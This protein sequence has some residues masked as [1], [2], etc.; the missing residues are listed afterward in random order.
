MMVNYYFD[1]FNN[2]IFASTFSDGTKYST[3]LIDT[4]FI[5]QYYLQLSNNCS[6]S[7]TISNTYYS[8]PLSP[9]ALPPIIT[10]TNITNITKNTSNTTNTNITQYTNITENNTSSTSNTSINSS[11]AVSQVNTTTF[12]ANNKTSIANNK[13]CFQ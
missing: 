8:I 3:M 4:Q 2:H 1:N 13:F 7:C 12:T 10:A 6:A 11:G 5:S 9:I